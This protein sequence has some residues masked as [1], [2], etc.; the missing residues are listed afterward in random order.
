MRALVL[1]LVAFAMSACTSAGSSPEPGSPSATP[2]D[3]PS[4]TSGEESA[5]PDGDPLTG[6]LGADSIEGGCGYLRSEDGTRF[7]VIYP[8]GWELSLRPLEL[9]APDGAVVARGGDE[10]TVIG[11]IAGDM[12]SICQIGPIFRASSVQR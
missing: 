12:A 2:S 1:V 6:I 3:R 9:R 7:E 10:V 5:P 8:D 4:P 11:E